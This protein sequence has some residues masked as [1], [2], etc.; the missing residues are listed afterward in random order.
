MQLLKLCPNIEQ[1]DIVFDASFSSLV[2]DDS[3]RR[4]FSSTI[5][6][7]SHCIQY[8]SKCRIKRLELIGHNPLQRCSCCAGKVWDAYLPPL[9][10]SLQFL[11]TLVLQHVLPS[12][13]VLQALA[14][15]TTIKKI[16]L[17]KS[18]ITIPRPK[19]AS[20]HKQRM[21]TIGLIPDSLW[22][23]VKSIEIYEDIE[24]STTWP[25]EKYLLEITNHIQDLESF[26]L[27]FGTLEENKRMLWPEQDCHF[28]FRSTSPLLKLKTKC[29]ESLKRISL[30]N[31]PELLF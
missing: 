10:K 19:E 1:L 7:L 26:L 8:E 13:Q 5:D 28:N 9:L 3:S 16:V 14:C 11:D 17:H 18:I 22:K 6:K 15:Q 12:Q 4:L 24:E 23:Q 2:S 29:G 25:A 21:T 31:V 27:Q 30:V 20:E